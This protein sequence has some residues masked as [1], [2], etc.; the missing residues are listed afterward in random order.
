MRIPYCMA[1]NTQDGTPLIEGG[2][3][4][5]G[6]R[7]G[8]YRRRLRRLLRA[9][10]SAVPLLQTRILLFGKRADRMGGGKGESEYGENHRP[11]KTTGVQ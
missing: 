6:D 7:G 1:K 3:A 8:F 2:M 10:R 9:P 4:P 5:V 11:G